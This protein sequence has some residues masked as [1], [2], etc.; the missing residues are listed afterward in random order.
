MSASFKPKM[1]VL[2]AV[3]QRLW[4]RLVK[5]TELG[6]VLYGGTAVAL[7]LGHR[8]SIDFDFFTEAPLDRAELRQAFPFIA[9]ASVLQEKP[10]TWTILVADESSEADEVKVSFFGG[11]D[12][13]RVGEP[14]YTDDRN[15]EVA[16][17]DDLMATKLKVLLQRVESKDYLDIAAMLGAGISLARGLAAARAMYGSGFQPSESLKALT[18]FKGG[19]LEMVPDGIRT[20]LIEA[21]SAV[22]DLPKVELRSRRLTGSS[23]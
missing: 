20:M 6:L 14:S 16:S 10:Q 4:P 9:H 22:G 7:R 11:I 5:T 8:H 21:V 15:L 18:Y 13:G 3:Q 17:L 2:P 1:H 23:P 12:I 19:D